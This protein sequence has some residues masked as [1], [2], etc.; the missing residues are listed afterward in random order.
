MTTE[1]P[2]RSTLHGTAIPLMRPLARQAPPAQAP[3]ALSPVALATVLVGV[4]LAM[5]DFFIV[6]VALPTMA[7]DLHASTASLELVVSGYATAYAVLLVVGGRLGDSRGRRRLFLAGIVAFTVTSLLCGLAPTANALIAARVLQG[8]AAAMLVPQTL[9]TI[10]AT[11]D[12]TSRARA[13]GWFGAT[14]GIA[15][16]VGQVVGGLLVSANIDGSGWRPI[17]LVNVPIGIVGYAF[18]RRHVPETRSPSAARPD[19]PGTVLLAAAVVAVLIPL[20]EGR[21]L[22]WP[23]WAIAMLAS[24]PLW[25][26]G[27]VAVERH[28]E[29]RGHTPLVPP[30]VMRHRSMRRG[31][32]L[33][34]PFFAGF[35]AFM[36]VYALVVQG[37]LGFSPLMAGLALAPMAAT[38]LAASLLMPRL[39]VQHGRSVITVGAIIQLAGLVLL[40]LTLETAWPAVNAG[41]LAGGLA[42]MGFGQGLVMPALIRVVLSEVPITEAGVGSGVLTTTQQVS[43]AIGVATLGTLFVSLASAGHVGTLHA[44]DLILGLQALVAAGIAI[45]SR[46]LGAEPAR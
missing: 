1:A 44:A 7:D 46:G 41:E 39:V 36:F 37:R 27:F 5:V 43:L 40:V 35:G 13:L 22:G 29:H 8:A 12:M 31:L 6:N 2:A 18:A 33:A 24:A 14:G 45:G 21:A 10:Q 4:F 3:A 30:S 26:G 20:T 15:A 16:V 38:F 32:M 23:V 42:V 34:G 28:L 11:G 19:L 17:F 25:A 9:S